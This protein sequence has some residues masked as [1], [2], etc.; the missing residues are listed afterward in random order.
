MAEASKNGIKADGVEGIIMRD[1]STVWMEVPRARDENGN[2]RG[3]YGIYPV[4]S[5]NVL[6]EDTWSYGS[7]DAG[8][9]VGQTIG[10]VIRRNVARRTLPVSRLRTAPMWMCTKT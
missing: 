5:Q 10:A 3:T 1:V 2:L 9:Y 6:I 8:I 7:A 4:K